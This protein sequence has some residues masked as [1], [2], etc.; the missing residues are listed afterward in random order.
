[1]YSHNPAPAL[2]SVMALVVLLLTHLLHLA[3]DSH[4]F[5]IDVQQP[6]MFRQNG[7]KQFG[8]RVRQFGS[9]DEK[10]IIV[11]APHKKQS[12]NDRAGG[13]FK[14]MN[15]TA[16][17][18]SINNP[19]SE[20]N[21]PVGLSLSTN[22][23][24]LLT[25]CSPVLA[26]E[27]DKNMYFNGICYT[28]DKGLNLIEKDTVT[29]LY[30]ECTKRNIDLVFLF[31]G[32]E[33]LKGDDFTNNKNFII[34]I[35][36]NLTNTSIQF[37]AVQFS[38]D[39]RTE[40]NFSSYQ[41][42][43]DPEKLL[44]NVQHMKQ[45]TN[46]HNALDYTIGNLLYNTKY[47]AKENAT[48]VLLII[49]DGDP[50]DYNDDYNYV[51]KR[52]DEK[53][54]IRYVIGIGNVKIENLK[55]LA[56]EPRNNNTFYIDNYKGLKGI[57]DNL[58]AKI[59]NIEGEKNADSRSFVNEMSQ[60]GFSVA[61]AEDRLFL[62]AVG[63]SDWAGSVLEMK[64]DVKT[65]VI[66][67]M[68]PDKDTY[69]GYSI[70]VG[71]LG[72]A[73]LVIAGA[74]RYKHKG[75]VDIFYN[76]GKL[77]ERVQNLTGD[78]IGSYFG[79]EVCAV[80]LNSDGLTDILLVGAPQ[81]Y[82]PK[83][84]GM[85]YVYRVGAAP[86]VTFLFNVSGETGFQSARFGSSISMIQ[87]LNEDGLMDIA[88]G[89]PL[90]DDNR[91]SVYIFHGSANGMNSRYSQR[92][93]GRLL[94]PDLQFFGQSIHGAMDINGD[95]LTDI[96]V[97][98]LGTVVLLSSRPVLNVTAK[99]LF[100]PSE[101][102]ISRFDC[103]SEGKEESVGNVTVCF[104]VCRA[105]GRNSDDVINISYWL[106]LD[107][108][109]LRSRAFFG[110]NKRLLPK[111][112][113]MAVGE[114]CFPYDVQMPKC[115]EDTYSPVKIKLN[116][117][118][119]ELL[120]ME[121]RLTAILNQ[122]SE[123]TVLSEVAFEKSCGKNVTCIADLQ[124]SASFSNVRSLIVG[125]QRRLNVTVL[126]E[127]VGD[128]S[129]NTTLSFFYPPALSFAK[130]EL[131]QF[132]RKATASCHD[133]RDIE[134]GGRTICK[135]SPPIFPG[136]TMAVYLNM[137][138]INFNSAWNETIEMNIRVASGNRNA[139]AGNTSVTI[140]LPIQ[141]AINVMIRGEESTT[142]MNFSTNV[143]EKKILTHKY[144]VKN[145]GQYVLPV[146]ITFYLPAEFNQTF[147]WNSGEPFTKNANCSQKKVEEKTE[148]MK[149]ECPATRCIVY[150][151]E[152]KS[153]NQSTPVYFT[154]EGEA[155]FNMSAH[156]KKLGF[157]SETKNVTIQS[158]AY[159]TYDQNLYVQFGTEDSK[160]QGRYH[161]AEISTHV[162]LTIELNLHFVYGVGAGGGLLFLLLLIVVFYK[163]G[164]FKRK[165]FD[166]DEQG[167]SM[168]FEAELDQM[169]TLPSKD[170]QKND[171]ADGEK[172]P[173]TEKDPL[174]G[175]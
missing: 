10:W 157:S 37:A 1:M 120:N 137:F 158:K 159:L 122:A 39:V 72:K 73:S 96:A 150:H 162:D 175:E 126:L 18:Q 116:F 53:H 168:N 69:L 145:I 127:N 71:H 169:S 24:S 59:Y 48:K 54:I 44:A 164:F 28:Y 90:E 80:D 29:P 47:G 97:G 20:Q 75:M 85:V 123:T 43:R 81:Y 78:Q 146:N 110:N 56:S 121:G 152:I 52:L 102:S 101:I 19:G 153:L 66:L 22:G 11:S 31:D 84:E 105:N 5:N 41:E 6:Q 4:G 50:T 62:G 82:K 70:A 42:I 128:D 156:P 93:E 3:Q 87:D 77:W 103:L 147:T 40:F 33:S 143:Q 89:A 161:T 109:R 139:S 141:Y 119:I 92:I 63:T 144:Q 35:M 115:V 49:T 74:P 14:C 94:S 172:K 148:E 83:T 25:T 60:S 17:C 36:K 134:S 151:C 57:L 16:D 64:P 100:E 138:D 135:V 46:T 117:T 34:D 79:G 26:H 171:V 68:A 118:Q 7:T 8:Y 112:T 170:T 86:T 30:Q 108:F 149:Q 125:A 98:S 114:H 155:Y 76:S 104:R 88:I 38:S 165:K 133:G 173:P 136:K 130:N 160:R 124:L 99:I 21:L 154:F 111:V 113:L 174:S 95:A 58:Q 67:P 163:C 91:G 167:D 142:F 9:N 131:I 13:I 132:N 55:S 2:T 107:S 65:P 15:G 140:S 51:T 166:E 12:P 129:Y 106:E 27:C 61:Y 32:S 23:S 45:L